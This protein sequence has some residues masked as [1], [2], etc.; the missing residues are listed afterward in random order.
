MDFTG[1]GMGLK[2]DMNFRGQIWKKRYREIKH[3]L[4]NKEAFKDGAYYCYCAYVLRISRHSGFLWDIFA[5]FK[6]MRRKQNLASDFGIQR[7]NWGRVTMHFSEI[8]NLKFGK[9]RY[10]LLCILLLFRKM[11]A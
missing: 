6:T 10:T 2:M 9:K 11:V 3:Y 5:C 1:T 7:E 8:I 4:K